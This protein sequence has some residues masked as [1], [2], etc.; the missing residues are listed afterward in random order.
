MHV[1]LN[2]RFNGYRFDSFRCLPDFQKRIILTRRW[3]YCRQISTV[4]GLSLDAA[5]NFDV[6]SSSGGKPNADLLLHLASLVFKTGTAVFSVLHDIF[7]ES[8]D[9]RLVQVLQAA[10]ISDEKQLMD[11]LRRLALFSR[12]EPVCFCVFDDDSGWENV[13][14]SPRFQGTFVWFCTCVCHRTDADQYRRQT[15]RGWR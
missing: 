6:R 12:S 9:L 5:N 1:D 7:S 14:L 11:W 4:H 13:F 2:G 10:E 3:H 15:Q 8:D